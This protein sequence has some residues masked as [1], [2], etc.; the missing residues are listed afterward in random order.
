VFLS[1]PHS[2]SDIAS[3]TK[4]VGKLLRTTVSVEEL[5]EHHPRL[6][7]L[8]TWYR[9]HVADFGIRTFV[10]CEKL[11]TIGVL[12]VNETTADPRIPGVRPIPLDEDH[13]TI[14]KP[15]SR[16]HQIYGRIH[17]LLEETVLLSGD[18]NNP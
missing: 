15:S 1:T 3:W 18:P 14:C 9:D 17:R 10:Y 5:E 8:N 6:R 13:V 11:P 16:E 2:G 4:Y 7:E 12:V